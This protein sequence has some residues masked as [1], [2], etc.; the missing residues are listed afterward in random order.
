MSEGSVEV[1]L[2]GPIRVMRGGTAVQG[3][4]SRKALAL[5]CYV[6]ARACPV[7]RAQLAELF[8]GDRGE[9]LGRANLSRVLHNDSALLP[10]CLRTTRADVTLAPPPA[11]WT[12]VTAFEQLSER[13]DLQALTD[14]VELYQGEFM[15][16]IYL[17]GCPEFETWLVTEQEVW[18][19]RMAGLLNA[20]IAALSEA[21]AYRQAMDYAG[22]LLALDPWREEAH[23]QVMLLQALT[24]QRSAALAQFE[25]C[26]R[27]LQAEL[28]VEPS[29]QTRELYERIRAGQ[30]PQNG[31]AKPAG[32]LMATPP[33]PRVHPPQDHQQRIDQICSRLDHPGCRLLVLT[34][35]TPTRRCRLAR[36]AAAQR[37]DQLR[38][39]VLDLDLAPGGQPCF[40]TV[41]A[42]ALRLPLQDHAEPS[43]QIF[44]HLRDK[45][46]LLVLR[47]FPTDPLGARLLND[48]LKRAPDVQMLVTAGQPLD[49]C[50]EW[51]LD[52][53]T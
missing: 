52:L 8:W 10:G 46:M 22:R 48:I 17:D 41:L 31:T 39:G 47:N 51:I 9:A 35:G 42:A 34:G 28:G 29:R 26:R 53:S 7:A 49:L 16:G 32:P 27:V 14:A 44:A 50:G 36:R 2:L 4:E 45:Q 13:G 11:C 20:L 33:A 40:A 19:Q 30:S 43:T 18:R 15:E 23:R 38:H 5:L 12:D 6:A 3:F 24:G 1:R 37:R 21:G 25:S